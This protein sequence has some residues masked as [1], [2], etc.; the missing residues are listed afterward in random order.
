MKK[1]FLLVTIIFSL[2]LFLNVYAVHAQTQNVASKGDEASDFALDVAQGEEQI[3]NDGEAQVGRQEVIGAEEPQADQ[4]NESVP[5]REAIAP[6]EAKE[7]KQELLPE[8]QEQ[9]ITPEVQ[10]DQKDETVTG[11]NDSSAEEAPAGDT[12]G[13]VAPTGVK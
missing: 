4:G 9:T 11:Q 2:I 13:E 12:G 10:P 8:G 5:T 6:Q 1:I 3:K 7:D